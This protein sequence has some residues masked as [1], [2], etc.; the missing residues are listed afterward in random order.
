MTKDEI[1]AQP[2]YQEAIKE[3][4]SKS[5]DFD[6]AAKVYK[7]N[8]N[9]A[10]EQELEQASKSAWALYCYQMSYILYLADGIQDDDVNA[11]SEATKDLKQIV[12]NNLQGKY[13]YIMFITKPQTA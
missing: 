13:E 10:K 4:Y 8:Q 5:M 12:F 7:E 2:K 11:A 6:R 1:I 3:F 9:P